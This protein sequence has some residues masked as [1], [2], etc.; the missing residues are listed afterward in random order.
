MS[1]SERKNDVIICGGHK[2]LRRT[3]CVGKN[4]EYHWRCRYVRKYLCK[5]KLV[6]LNGAGI[7]EA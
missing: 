2:F 5:V 1:K 3:D 4:G 6:T 7:S